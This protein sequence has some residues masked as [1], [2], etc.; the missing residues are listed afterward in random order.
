M[1]EALPMIL[2][3][4]GS[5]RDYGGC[6]LVHGRYLLHATTQRD[7]A[8]ASM[9]DIN[10]TDEFVAAAR[11]I[12]AERSGTRIETI[13]ADFRDAATFADREETDAS[14]PYEVLLHQENYVDV[15]RHVCGKTKRFVCVAQP[16]LREE[17]FDLP[18]AAVLLQFYDEKLKDA[19]RAESLWPPEPR[20]EEFTSAHWMWGHTSSH[21]VDV[22]RG[23][24]WVLREGT[25]VDNLGGPYWE[26]SLLV[27]ERRSAPGRIPV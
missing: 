1:K 3:D 6:Y 27:F 15:M 19:L 14:L 13:R 26:Y 4:I 25:A 11:E 23:L 22:M 17:L 21:L 9:I 10:P 20:T 7:L 12:A 5:L 2:P 8:F 18:A 24:G 16:C